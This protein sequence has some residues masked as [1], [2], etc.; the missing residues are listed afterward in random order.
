MKKLKYWW[1]DKG[2]YLHRTLLEGIKNLIYWFPVIWK[3]RNWDQ[4]DIF[5][6]FKHKL[7]A[8]ARYIA[9]KD[10]HLSAQNDARNMRICISLMSAL[11]DSMYSTEY[12]DYYKT[13]MGVECVENDIE[14]F[15]LSFGI[16]EENFDDYFKKYPLIYKRVLKGEG[17][18]TIKNKSDNM[19]EK[20]R[21][22]MNIGQINHSRAKKLLFKIMEDNIEGWWD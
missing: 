12:S 14:I 18:F 6:I 13:R 4:Y 22:A 17:V 1:F 2:M 8:Q 11:Q 21:I 15:H 19:E 7:A 10:R 9:R 3:D 20:Q 16:L 5:E